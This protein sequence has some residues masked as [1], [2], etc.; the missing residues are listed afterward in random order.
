MPYKVA[1]NVE[2]CS[3][4]AVVKSDTEELVA[5]H[6]TKVAAVQQVRAL[7]ANVPDAIK[8]AK[9]E[10]LVALQQKIQSAEITATSLATHHYITKEL[11]QRGLDFSTEELFSK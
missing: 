7:Y 9:T 5:C 11:G 2:G 8:K 10:S 4:F 6:A 3:G 1:E